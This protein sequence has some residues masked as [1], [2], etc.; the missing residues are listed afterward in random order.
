MQK[1]RGSQNQNWTDPSPRGTS[2]ISL[3]H[4]LPKW[5]NAVR[6]WQA[7]CSYAA[8]EFILPFPRVCVD[9][10]LKTKAANLAEE[11]FI[12]KVVTK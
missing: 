1:N 5:W 6:M 8:R 12:K 3:E 9:V 4:R 7:G 10:S 2:V 11:N